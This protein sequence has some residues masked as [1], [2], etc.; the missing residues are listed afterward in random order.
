[1]ANEEAVAMFRADAIAAGLP[2]HYDP[3]TIAMTLHKWLES[4]PANPSDPLWREAWWLSV[5]Y[6]FGPDDYPDEFPFYTEEFLRLVD[7][8]DCGD[9]ESFYGR[10]ADAC[11][12]VL[13]RQAV[14]GFRRTSAE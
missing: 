12:G 11:R 1:M 13:C 5:G 4:V 14:S 10:R 6:E 3:N 8:P 9:W 7:P 2:P